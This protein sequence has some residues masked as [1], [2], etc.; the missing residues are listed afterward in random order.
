MNKSSEDFSSIINKALD[1]Q[2]DRLPASVINELQ[3]ARVNALNTNSQQSKQAK[4]KVTEKTSILS[5]S[6]FGGWQASASFASVTL[7]AVLLFS[8]LNAGSNSGISED[9]LIANDGGLSLLDAE[10]SEDLDMLN[11]IEFALWLS[12]QSTLLESVK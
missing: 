7:V 2:T 5:F 9:A 11:D 4:P 8:Q 10:L 6:R 1:D 3:A 12:E